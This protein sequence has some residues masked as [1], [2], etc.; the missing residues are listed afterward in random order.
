MPR[1]RFSRWLASIHPRVSVQ[2]KVGGWEQ[3]VVPQSPPTDSPA[4]NTNIGDTFLLLL[5]RRHALP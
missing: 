5:V 1:T 4:T 2:D 3:P